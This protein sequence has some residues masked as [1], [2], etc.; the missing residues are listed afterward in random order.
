MDAVD[1]TGI[2]P[3]RGEWHARHGPSGTCRTRERGAT[4]RVRPCWSRTRH[5]HDR[6]RRHEV[7]SLRRVPA[8]A[9][10][11]PT[12]SA[13][14]RQGEVRRRVAFEAT[15]SAGQLPGERGRVRPAPDDGPQTVQ[16]PGRADGWPSRAVRAHVERRPRS[17]RSRSRD[18]AASCRAAA[19]RARPARGVSVLRMRGGGSM[20]GSQPGKGIDPQMIRDHGAEAAVRRRDPQ[21]RARGAGQL[22]QQATSSRFARCPRRGTARTAGGA[23]AERPGVRGCHQFR[24]QPVTIDPRSSP[25]T[26]PMNHTAAARIAT[27]MRNL[28]AWTG[29]CRTAERCARGSARA[30][31]WLL[32]AK[33]S[34]Q[35]GR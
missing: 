16:G 15:A 32:L 6:G 31:P 17:R 4:H 24:N 29:G 18:A 30:L 8:A 35:S 19:G 12:R 2:G 28:T 7:R 1:L 25:T 26:L 11:L 21:D 10:R 27:Q 5:L 9:G 3:A 34:S 33:D 13:L 20:D 23:G 22:E 14:R